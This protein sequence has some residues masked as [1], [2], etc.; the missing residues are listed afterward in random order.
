[1]YNALVNRYPVDVLLI[2]EAI[3]ICFQKYV[4]AILKI[5]LYFNVLSCTDV[6]RVLKA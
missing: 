5:S 1:M 3:N 4:I 2:F 6:T